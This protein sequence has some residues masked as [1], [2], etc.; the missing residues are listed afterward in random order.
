MG[1][2]VLEGAVIAPMACGICSRWDGVSLSEERDAILMADE[3]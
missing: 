3:A 2:G 1:L